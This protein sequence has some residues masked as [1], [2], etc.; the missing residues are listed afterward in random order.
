[1]RDFILR[2]FNVIP[3]TASPLAD[4]GLTGAVLLSPRGGDSPGSSQHVQGTSFPWEKLRVPLSRGPRQERSPSQSP[5]APPSAGWPGRCFA[6]CT[7]QED[8]EWGFGTKY[9]NAFHG[10][11]DQWVLGSPKQIPA[12]QSGIPGNVFYL[13]FLLPTLVPDLKPLFTRPQLKNMG[14][15]GHLFFKSCW[16]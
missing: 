2:D 15:Y 13:G 9:S 14:S 11:K 8:A 5:G 1:M 12:I 16:N 4:P 6:P 10:K 7:R 3:P